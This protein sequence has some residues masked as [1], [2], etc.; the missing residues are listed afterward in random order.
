MK[1]KFGK[2]GTPRPIRL[3]GVKR[4]NIIAKVAGAGSKARTLDLYLKDGR[5][6]V[7]SEGKEVEL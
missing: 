7:K 5:T 3:F 1:L 6:T 2:R 4:E